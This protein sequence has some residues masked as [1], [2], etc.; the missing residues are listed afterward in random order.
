MGG[1][2]QAMAPRVVFF[3][4]H[5]RPEMWQDGMA[6]SLKLLAKDVDLTVIDLI[7]QDTNEEF[8]FAFGIGGFN[9]IV[10]KKLANWKGKKGLYVAGC[11]APIPSHVYLYDVLFYE[12]DWVK[13]NYLNGVDENLVEMV[14]CQGGVNTTIYKPMNL[15]KIID[16]IGIG[17]LASWKRWEKMVNKTGVRL[18]VGEYQAGNEQES[19]GI[20]RYLIANGIAFMPLQSA[21]TLAYLINLSKCVYIPASTT[22]GGE[23]AVCEARACGV[24]VEIEPDNPKLQEYIDWQPLPDQNYCHQQFLEG[25]NRILKHQ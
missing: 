1:G 11:V 12:S 5:P 24:P 21:T 18:V 19:L 7:N 16:Y 10:D 17:A 4:E 22:G 8:D 25:I 14:K 23:R 13:Q 15:P 3:H 9:S 20:A 6:E 2:S